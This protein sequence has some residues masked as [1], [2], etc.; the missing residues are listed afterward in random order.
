M[1]GFA[2]PRPPV[3]TRRTEPAL[4]L[5]EGLLGLLGERPEAGPPAPLRPDDV[6]ALF[7]AAWVAATGEA[8]IS[9]RVVAR[10]LPVVL[11]AAAIARPSDEVLRAR[12]G[13]TPQ[14]ARVARLLAARRTNAEVA[15]ALSIRPS[16]ARR[17]TEQVLSKLGV[18]SRTDVE[19]ALAEGAAA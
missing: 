19:A 6:E 10:V 2:A 13:L 11:G 5:R 17:H 14:E 3:H 12:F 16:T 9:P 8:W 15:E 1:S 4:L 7:E 18:S